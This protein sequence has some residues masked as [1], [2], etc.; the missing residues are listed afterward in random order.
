MNTIS[1][2]ARPLLGCGIVAGPL[3]VGVSVAQ[4]LVRD[5]FDFGRH[6]W[7][8]LANGPYGWI[9][10][11]NL[12]LVG[13]L[14]VAFAAGLRRAGAGRAASWLVAVFGAGMVAGGAFP[15]DP[16]FGFPAGTPDGPGTASLSGTLHLA[17]SGVGFVCLVVAAFLLA[18][19]FAPVWTRAVAV[20]FLAGFG[21][22][23]TGGGAVWA[24]LVFTGAI[25]LVWG[26]VTALAADEYRG[27]SA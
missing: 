12:I 21:C 1:G 19:Q 27:A 2:A 5:G 17:L 15:A 8:M 6:A 14:V 7:S 20:A 25:I 13:I 26:W 11:A 23:A 22:I 24:N 4:G 16:G 9:Q 10:S 3:Y 18:R